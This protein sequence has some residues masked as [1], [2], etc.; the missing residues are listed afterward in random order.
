MPAHSTGAVANRIAAFVFMVMDDVGGLD[1][2]SG[3]KRKS[4]HA[5]VDPQ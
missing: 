2:P 1:D 4:G 5:A 3:L